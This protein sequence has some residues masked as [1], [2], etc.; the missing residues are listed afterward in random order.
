ML[1]VFRHDCKDKANFGIGVLFDDGSFEKVKIE[2]DESGTDKIES[3]E[4]NDK[5][6]GKIIS[7][8]VDKEH[9]RAL[10]VIS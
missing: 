9:S 3:S 1:S 7:F 6:D 5:I 4:S 2:T 10:Y 8:D